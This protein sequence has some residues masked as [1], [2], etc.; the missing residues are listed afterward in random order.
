[1]SPLPQMRHHAG[2]H[3]GAIV[4]AVDP[5]AIHPLLQQIMNNPVIFSRLGSHGD[6]DS[7]VSSRMSRTEQGF[8]M[9]FQQ[10]SS[11]EKINRGDSQVVGQ[12]AGGLRIEEPG[13]H[14]FK[15][16]KRCDSARPRDERP[17]SASCS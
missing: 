6:H 8:S 15:G 2:P 7:D 16:R 4:S 10:M 17:S 12:T 1:M 13:K 5:H 3:L 14:G 9:L 11:F